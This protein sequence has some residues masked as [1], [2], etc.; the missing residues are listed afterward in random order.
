MTRPSGI[1]KRLLLIALIA[2]T[3]VVVQVVLASPPTASFLTPVLS[4]GNPAGG[5]KQ[6]TFTSDSTDPE[7]DIQTIDWDFDNDGTFEVSGDSVQ[8]TFPR[9]DTFPFRMRATDADTGGDG[10]ETGETTGSVTV[11][12]TAPTAAFNVSTAPQ[13]G[14]P[15]TFNAATSSDG[16]GSVA[17]Y[18]WDLDND[19]S[20]DDATG[21]TATQT[22]ATPDLYTVGL[23]VTD[24]CG[25]ASARR[26]ITFN[27]TNP[28]PTA[29][30]TIAPNP[31]KPGEAVTFTSTSTDPGGSIASYQWDLDDDD[32]YNEGGTTGETNAA[33]VTATYAAAGTY[34][35]K[36]IVTDNNGTPDDAVK[37]LRINRPPTAAFT[38][39]PNPA[40]INE[41]V[42]FNGA[43]SSDTDGTIA[44]YEWDYD[45]DGVTFNA[46]ATG[47][48][49]AAHAFPAVG[50]KTVALR[51][52]DNNGSA[53]IESRPVTV[54]ASRP[55]AALTWS[56]ANPLPGQAVTLRSTSTPSGSPGAPS[57][58]ATQWDFAFSPLTD[59]TLDGA[60]GSIV[61]S[62]ATPGAHTVAVKVTESGGGFDIA[63]ATIVVNAPP[64]ASFTVSSKPVERKPVTFA[65]TSTDPDG[66]IV[67][68]EWDFNKDGKYDRTGAVVTTSSL[69][70]GTRTI[71]LRV[72]DSKGAQ[73][74]ASKTIKVARKPLKKPNDIDTSALWSPRTRGVMLV[75]F[76]AT[77]PA[78]T[79]VAVT[80][81]GGGCPRGVFHKRSKKKRGAL[82]TFGVLEGRLSGGA[83][84]NVIF[85]RPGHLTGWDIITIRATGRDRIGLR[86][87]CKLSSKQ[88]KW[89]RCPS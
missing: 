33:T 68:Q 5:C 75:S 57:L 51:V 77:V 49:P 69:K 76:S 35:I 38:I 71:R 58:I 30:F 11:T 83:K 56:P 40:L 36:L 81:K 88:K 46:D 63:S 10:I 12:T 65:S 50:T 53:T 32:V 86:E 48:A 6:Y 27:V 79:S 41:P 28:A 80:C 18:A 15:V 21:V 37:N 25:V 43:S 73:V 70:A 52:T 16:D 55:N 44:L 8:H 66:P 61:T 82:L 42:A 26:E 31:A 84:I 89:K 4:N 7:T 13:V 87:G 34:A 72:T 60:G 23:V 17:S 47:A 19:G 2:A 29:N 22:Y 24:N 1:A 85:K 64:Q 20:A 14:T 3:F 78:N 9:A 74:T 67:Q 59:F 39:N 54:Q 45:Y 62:F